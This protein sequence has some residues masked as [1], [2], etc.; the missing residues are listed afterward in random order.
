[1]THGMALKSV[2]ASS[3]QGGR[4]LGPKHVLEDVALGEHTDGSLVQLV[5]HNEHAVD[6][7]LGHLLHHRLERVR[8][9]H[10]HDVSRSLQNECLNGVVV[11]GV[12]NDRTT[13]RTRIALVF[14]YL[15][16]ALHNSTFE[17]RHRFPQAP[18]HFRVV[19]DALRANKP[20][21]MSPAG[22]PDHRTKLV[23]WST[24]RSRVEMLSTTAPSSF[25][26]GSP[27]TP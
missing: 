1:M 24:L 6:V 20:P 25:T 16:I 8:I 14:A 15:L 13:N 10:V 23:C 17:E 22:S 27:V 9:Q 21:S 7:M 2:W 3:R 12:I 4:V 26:T 18:E 11:G 19:L 5:V